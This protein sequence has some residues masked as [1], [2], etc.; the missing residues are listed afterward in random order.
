[1]V[2]RKNKETALGPRFGTGVWLLMVLALAGAGARAEISGPTT[3]AADHAFTLKWAHRGVA[4]EL[5]DRSSLSVHAGG[6]AT[7]VKPAGT[8]VFAEVVCVAVPTSRF[9]TR[10]RA[11]AT[12]DTHT[13]NVTGDP[14]VPPTPDAQ[15]EH[16][17]TLRSGDLDGNGRTDVLI[18]RT[19][20]GAVDGTLQ[21]V[22][23]MQDAKGALTHKVPT[24]AE[25]AAA[26]K[27]AVNSS[28]SLDAVD[29]NFDGYVDR[30]VSGLKAIGADTAGYLVFAPGGQRGMA[31]LAVTAMGNAF[32]Q[33]FDDLR[34]S[35]KDST[36]WSKNVHY[37]VAH[38]YSFGLT[39]AIN[40]SFGFG[41]AYADRWS[42]CFPRII[43]VDTVLVPAPAYNVD[44]LAAK[45]VI[46]GIL[47]SEDAT[48]GARLFE[49]SKAFER[50]IGAHLFGFTDS[51]ERWDNPHDDARADR[52]PAK[53]FANILIKLIGWFKR[54][55]TEAGVPHEFNES[56]LICE[57]NPAHDPSHCT[58]DNMWCWLKKYPAPVAKDVGETVENGAEV[59]LV[60]D[61]PIQ[62]DVDEASRTIHNVTVDGHIFHNPAQKGCPHRPGQPAQ[63][64]ATR[65]SQTRRQVDMR[66]GGIWVDTQG[67]GSGPYPEVNELLG[68][69]VFKNVD[70]DLA[71]AA[72]EPE[73][74]H[75]VGWP[76][77]GEAMVVPGRPSAVVRECS[78]D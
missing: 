63:P 15:A 8:Y 14:A 34:E 59:T 77:S 12:V 49:L 72:L 19:T 23:L 30:I 61:N 71:W 35:F 38:V 22:L 25:L 36:Y 47:T 75:P 57:P 33:F 5:E 10:S 32:H 66:D 7:F 31:P 56:T 52:E 40:F 20:K 68:P 54:D 64:A 46:D 73:T 45:T 18:E 51:G 6:A 9:V 60:G 53:S 41:T 39:C 16:E 4:T 17:F 44:A 62:V 55:E 43:R 3:A 27:F 78:D 1:M 37:T 48:S 21:T 29:F 13:V 67:Q 69:Y 11:C 42:A 76:V 70:A 65:C 24:P 28:L 74:I 2:S 50:V 26:R 58:L